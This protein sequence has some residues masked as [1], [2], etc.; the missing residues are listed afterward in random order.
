MPIIEEPRDPDMPVPVHASIWSAHSA[1][2]EPVAFASLDGDLSVDVVIVGGGI[3]GVTAAS[4]LAR[5]GRTVALLEARAIGMG[6]TGHSTGNL[7]ATVDASLHALGAKWGAETVKAV[8]RS[9][10][11]AIERIEANIAEFRIK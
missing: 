6:T 10:L 1:R 3:C 4:E 9:R 11:R 7:Y 2:S 8:V 5:N